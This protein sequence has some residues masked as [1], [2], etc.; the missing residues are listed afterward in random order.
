[1]A[2]GQLCDYK[3]FVDEGAPAY[4][5][6]LVPSLPREDLRNLLAAEGIEI[7]RPDAQ[8]FTDSLGGALV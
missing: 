2:I 5:A 8:G 6:V 3:R 1:M 4:L 7:I